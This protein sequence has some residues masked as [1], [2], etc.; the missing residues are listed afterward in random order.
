VEL[1]AS[2]INIHAIKFNWSDSGDHG[3]L[4]H[5]NRPHVDYFNATEY[6]RE[7][8]AQYFRLYMHIINFD[9]NQINVISLWRFHGQLKP[10]VFQSLLHFVER[11]TRQIVANYIR[12]KVFGLSYTYRFNFFYLC[13]FPLANFVHVMVAFTSLI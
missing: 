11:D 1:L 7:R 10:S 5:I 8:H 2:G 3:S 6:K 12:I 4:V 13:R 9:Q